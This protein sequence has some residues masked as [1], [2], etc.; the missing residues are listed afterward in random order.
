[1]VPCRHRRTHERS[2]GSEGAYGSFSGEEE[3]E[4]EGEETL[5]GLEEASP[6]ESE[7][8]YA[9]ASFQGMSSMSSGSGGLGGMMGGVGGVGVGVGGG[10]AA[11]SQLIGAGHLMG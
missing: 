3:E 11:P 2:D 6:R 10:M 5:A 1:M 7:T 4:Y 8:G 9:P